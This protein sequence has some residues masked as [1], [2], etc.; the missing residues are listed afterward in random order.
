MAKVNIGIDTEKKTV[1]IKVDG[2]KLSNTSEVF[3]S[4]EEGPYSF[5]LEILQHEKLDDTL[6][7]SIRLIANEQGDLV[8]DVITD[9]YQY[10]EKKWC[11]M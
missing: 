10:L 9:I 7:K 1:D 8:E 11:N 4:T 3:I 6:R 2:K 5:R